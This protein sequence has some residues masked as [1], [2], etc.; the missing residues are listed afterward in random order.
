MLLNIFNPVY[1]TYSSASSTWLRGFAVTASRK[2]NTLGECECSIVETT[3][4]TWT[5]GPRQGDQREMEGWSYI[6]VDRGGCQ[7]EG[8]GLARDWP[9]HTHLHTWEI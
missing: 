9:T 2:F 4:L 7:R 8:E 3:E 1:D 5:N 6:F